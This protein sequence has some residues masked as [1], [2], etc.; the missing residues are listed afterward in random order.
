MLSP[1]TKFWMGLLF[2]L[3]Q[4]LIAFECV[5][6]EDCQQLMAKDE[7]IAL[8]SELSRKEE[9]QTDVVSMTRKSKVHVLQQT[10]RNQ[11]QVC[12]F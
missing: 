5:N 2:S 4:R 12:E 7:A 10:A 3:L 9:E 8:L 6:L 1:F 11:E